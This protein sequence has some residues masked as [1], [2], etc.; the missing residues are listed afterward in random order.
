LKL[1]LARYRDLAAFAQFASDLDKATQ[2]QLQRG[3]RLTELL[4]QVNY[5]PYNVTDEVM[6]IY[7]GTNGY[8]DEVPVDQV[9]RYEQRL[10]GFMRQRYP[11]VVSSIQNDKAISK[12][13]EERLK[14][15]LSEFSAA[16]LANTLPEDPIAGANALSTEGTGGNNGTLNSVANAATTAQTTATATA[17][18]ATAG[19][20]TSGTP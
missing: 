4:K 7:A 12:E 10:I 1:D 9:A 20:A 18:S 6:S 13:M 11:D 5:K 2:A 16:F 15:A 3:Q 8:L 19:S 17:G 14:G